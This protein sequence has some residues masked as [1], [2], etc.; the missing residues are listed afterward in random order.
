MVIEAMQR[1][2]YSEVCR[3][4]QQTLTF[5]CEGVESQ[6]Y[7][8]M[9]GDRPQAPWWMNMHESAKDGVVKRIVKSLSV[10][11]LHSIP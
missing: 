7:A 11:G 6:K 1:V 8:V 3:V 10:R 9:R 2:V 5:R 4:V